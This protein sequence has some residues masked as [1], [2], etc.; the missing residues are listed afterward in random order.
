MKDPSRV[1]GLKTSATELEPQVDLAELARLA[2]V[3]LSATEATQLK[4][5]LEALLASVQRLQAVELKTIEAP[6]SQ[7]LRRADQPRAGRRSEVLR[8]AKSLEKDH[9]VVDDG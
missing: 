8:R 4:A 1:N 6:A 2:E 5:E 3:E 9:I 7:A